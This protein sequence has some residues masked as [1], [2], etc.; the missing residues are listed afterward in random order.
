MR[1]KLFSKDFPPND[2]FIV[3]V[4]GNGGDE[5]S[6]SSD[7]TSHSRIRARV[8]GVDVFFTPLLLIASR[9]MDES[10]HANVGFDPSLLCI[11]NRLF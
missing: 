11:S 6:H 9:Q 8:D 4:K 3:G 10:F 7:D 5:N 1:R 2:S